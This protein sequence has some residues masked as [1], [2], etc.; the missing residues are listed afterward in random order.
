M[1]RLSS[2]ATKENDTSDPESRKKAEEEATIK[3]LEGLRVSKDNQD[4]P[5]NANIDPS[6]ANE[7]GTQQAEES[8]GQDPPVEPTGDSNDKGEDAKSSPPG[9]IQL[10]E[11]F[12]EQVVNMVRAR[13]LP[14]QDTVALLVSLV[15]LAL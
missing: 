15:N 4:I 1:D 7:N 2:Y 12:F 10:Y 11:I 14:I 13:S 5:N 6:E 3:L 9:D 8:Q